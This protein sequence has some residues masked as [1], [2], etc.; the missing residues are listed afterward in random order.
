VEYA[1]GTDLS[2]PTDRSG[3]L[4][5]AS[6]NHLTLGFTPR[7]WLIL[8]IHQK[9]TDEASK[10][11]PVC[12]L[13]LIGLLLA[14]SELYA[15]GGSGAAPINEA[16]ISVTLYVNPTAPAGGN[17]TQ[18]SPFNTIQAALNRAIN[19]HNAANQGVRVL[20][21]PGIY[22]EGTPGAT[23]AIT[24]P[25]PT[26][27]PPSSS[28]A[29][30]GTPPLPPTRATSSSPARKTGPAAGPPNVTAPGLALGPTRGASVPTTPAAAIRPK[31]CCATN[32]SL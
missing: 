5:D 25:T 31:P 16:G 21:A 22:R 20:L 9:L 13:A 24:L 27:P 4:L 29:Q 23:T 12:L 17:G 2:D 7:R 18:S 10:N 8:R 26:T 6:S 11:L 14:P 1:L 30:G 19:T 32:S 15:L 28:K 3:L